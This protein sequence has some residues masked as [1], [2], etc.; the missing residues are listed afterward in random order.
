MYRSFLCSHFLGWLSGRRSSPYLSSLF[1]HSYSHNPSAF[2][3]HP[4]TL[5]LSKYCQY[6]NIRSR[7]AGVTACATSRHEPPLSFRL[8]SSAPVREDA[9]KSFH[10]SVVFVLGTLSLAKEKGKSQR[11][12]NPK[13]TRQMIFM[14][15]GRHRV[16]SRQMH[17]RQ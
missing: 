3:F 15:M 2:Y 12:K 10:C 17:R 13:R 4:I 6:Y 16:R 11:E 9:Y 14:L 7:Q 8:S 5:L 1:P